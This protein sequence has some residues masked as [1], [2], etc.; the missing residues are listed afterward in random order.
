MSIA[1]IYRASGSQRREREREKERDAAML[2][3]LL[4]PASSPMRHCIG[5]DIV[6]IYLYVHVCVC[7]CVCVRAR[8]A[9]ASI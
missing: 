9:F 1:G 7:V 4:S 5:L 3:S 8:G 2:P 6:I